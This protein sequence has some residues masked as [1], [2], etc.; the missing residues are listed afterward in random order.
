MGGQPEKPKPPGNPP[1]RPAPQHPA[2]TTEPP[3]PIPAPPIDP[4]PAPIAA[5]DG[6]G[7]REV[8]ALV[9]DTLARWRRHWRVPPQSV[10]PPSEGLR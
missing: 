8:D 7:G 1:T 4:P 10:N 6:N 2:P 5:H 3:R 9:A